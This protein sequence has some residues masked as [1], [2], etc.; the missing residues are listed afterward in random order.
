M[1]V[2]ITRVVNLKVQM[3][4]HM[5]IHTPLQEIPKTPDYAPSRTFYL[6]SVQLLPVAFMVRERC[7]KALGNLITRRLSETEENRSLPTEGIL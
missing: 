3:C 1:S 2:C 7:Y 5:H 4:L 6:F